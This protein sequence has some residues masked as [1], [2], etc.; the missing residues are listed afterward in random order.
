MNVLY[1]HT[2][3]SGRVLSPY[4]YHV[5]TP[6]MEA[7]AGDCAVFRNCY[8]AGPTC[9]PS[10]AAMLSGMYPHQNGMLGL[11]QRGFSMDYEKHLVQF[12]NRHQYHTVL[13]GIQHEAGWYLDQ[14]EGEGKIGYTQEIT[15][16][17]TGYR[18]EDLI[19]W[20]QANAGQVCRWLEHYDGEKPFFLS[21]GMYATHRRFPDRTD[22]TTTTTICPDYVLPPYPIPDS[23]ETREDFSRY[24]V[25]VKS[26]DDCFGKVI[27]CLQKTGK[28]DDTIVLFTTDH[29]LASP[30]C[31][32]TLFDSGIG[33]ALMV[34]V[35]ESASNGHA[36]DGLVSQLDVYPSLCELLGLDKP[37]YLEG[38]SFVPML[39]DPAHKI[40]S[41]IYA[42]VNFH[43]S[44]EPIRC[45]R[46]E[47]YKYIRYYDPSYLRI[48]KSNI[49]ESPTKEYLM[50]KGLGDQTKYQEA[51]YDLVFDMGE[52]NNLSEAS[53]FEA[54][55]EDLSRRLDQHLTDT[56][57]PILNGE[58]PL[59][60]HW[61][62]NT[63]ECSKAS[64][65]NP[66]DYIRLG[67]N[68]I[69]RE[70]EEMV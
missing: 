24:M 5:P 36:I 29:G 20:D 55:R 37:D 47:R 16:D 70:E 57:D 54:I 11:A 18:Q 12:L 13:C 14:G 32:C 67:R 52:R 43:T 61:K 28:L 15:V 31:K 63:K 60:P 42:E 41:E 56:N 8:C 1:I 9:S 30:F 27:D 44:Y 25:S 17:N 58:I 7:F 6:N 2:H 26:A 22:D 3:D 62:V 49:D 4:G 48:N 35:P 53:G 38:V 64:S 45:I 68:Y 34:R 50:E 19:D 23:R 40:R 10:R 21:Y 69:K 51:L 33:V 65:K 66:D 59:L 39:S 46:T